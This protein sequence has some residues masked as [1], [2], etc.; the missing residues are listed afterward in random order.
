MEKV[1]ATSE[2]SMIPEFCLTFSPNWY[3]P[4]ILSI[5]EEG[6]LAYG[7]N[8]DVYVI[9]L[10]K[11]S[12]VTS[13]RCILKSGNENKSKVTA[14]LSRMHLL[15][16]GFADGTLCIWNEKLNYEFIKS[17]SFPG[18]EI[19]N[20]AEGPK[21]K[22]NID[23]YLGF[24]GGE[25]VRYSLETQNVCKEPEGDP[26][27]LRTVTIEDKQVLLAVF[28][29]GTVLIFSDSNNL[30]FKWESKAKLFNAAEP[31]TAKNCIT[32]L[33]LTKKNVAI[34]LQIN[35][36]TAEG[37]LQFEITKEYRKNFAFEKNVKH[38]D[39]PEYLKAQPN[40]HFLNPSNVKHYFCLYT[41]I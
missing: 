7:A 11:R 32:L 34:L 16:A 31:L 22:E 26:L 12:F 33:L 8:A 3:L 29:S 4:Q 40:I 35:A 28:S 17:A 23:L 19:L 38:K 20:I 9:D 18:K 41:Y 27:F 10:L 36:K 25:V 37:S 2:K 5:S 30:L 14:V 39:D 21:F 24:R 15:F 1:A 6:L 13:V